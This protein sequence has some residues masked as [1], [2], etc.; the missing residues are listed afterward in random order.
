MPARWLAYSDYVV[1][2]QAFQNFGS[3][4][5]FLFCVAFTA[6]P[7]CATNLEEERGQQIVCREAKADTG[8]YQARPHLTHSVP[9]GDQQCSGATIIVQGLALDTARLDYVSNALFIKYNETD[10]LTLIGFNPN[11][12]FRSFSDVFVFTDQTICARDLIAKGFDLQGTAQ[13]EIIIGTNAT[14]RITG[15]AGDDTLQG[16]GGDDVYYYKPGD[17]IDCIND[18]SGNDV[19]LFSGGLA[20]N[21]ITATIFSREGQSIARLRV[22]D[23]KWMSPKSGVDVLLNAEGESPIETVKFAD[24]SACAFSGILLAAP[25]YVDGDSQKPA[26]A[27]CFFDPAL[28]Q[29]AGLVNARAR[30]IILPPIR[31]PTK[32]SPGYEIR[33]QQILSVDPDVKPKSDDSEANGQ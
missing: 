4:L 20:V 21:N 2:K 27:T 5:R 11:D 33:K 6:L 14:D 13:S 1:N 25:K 31:T 16:N 12:A 10:Q 9:R 8:G 23:N 17:G 26:D 22:R 30:A 24:G 15:H 32:I 18:H 28:A 7:G 19:I 29:Q 3:P